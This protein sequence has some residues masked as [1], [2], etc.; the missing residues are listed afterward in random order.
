ML[1][2]AP[3]L[4][5]TACL[6]LAVIACTSPDPLPSPTTSPTSGLP[7]P[8]PQPTP[9][10]SPSTPAPTASPST[11][12]PTPSPTGLA[13]P[14]V[15]QRLPGVSIRDA[16][17]GRF[18]IPDCPPDRRPA[19]EPAAP[20]GPAVAGPV[21]MDL[22]GQIG[23]RP[24]ALVLE[25]RQLH[26]GVGARVVEFGL[27]PALHETSSSDL[28]PGIVEGLAADNDLLVAALGVDGLAVLER[29]GDG[30]RLSAVLEMPG[31]ALAATI[32]GQ[33]AFVA[34][35]TGGLRIV[36][37]ARPPD[38]RE[39]ASL[40]EHHH[41]RGVAV[42][43]GLAYVAAA[44]E[45]LVVVDVSDPGAPRE[46]GRRATG[47]F[48]FSVAVEDSTVYVAD[49]WG[50]LQVVDVADPAQPRLAGSL[51]T[52]G[53]AMDISLS[54]GVAYLAAGAQG[55]LAVD[56]TDAADLQVV[57]AIPLSLRHATGIAVAD[58]LAF[59]ADPFE[60]MHVVDVRS[61][62]APQAVAVWQPLLEGQHVAAA[63]GYAYVAGGRSGLVVVDASDPTRP[64][65]VDAQPT[66][67]AAASVVLA[68]DRV[69]FSTLND[70][71]LDVGFAL[72]WADTAGGRLSSAGGP[73]SMDHVV[74]AGT[75]LGPVVS[76]TDE[77]GL[78][79][80]DA[81]DS[82]PCR[83][84]FH[85]TNF[86]PDADVVA[87][88]RS[89][90][91]AGNTAYVT[92]DNEGIYVFDLADPQSPRLLSQ[93][94]AENGD[95]AVI[96]DWLYMV[97][98]DTLM[99]YEL[100]D[101]Q[102]PRLA[103]TTQLPAETLAT[104]PRRMAVAGGRL[105]IATGFGVLAID[106]SDPARP[107]VAGELAIPGGAMSVAG[108]EGN[109]YVGTEQ[110]GLVIVVLSDGTDGPT[111]PP[112]GPAVPSD[113]NGM[114][115]PVVSRAPDLPSLTE[116]VRSDVQTGC[117]VTSAEDAGPGS[118][119]DCLE[120]VRPGRAVVFDPA[121]FSP[122]RPITIRLGSA[123]PVPA[124]VVLDGGGGVVLDGGGEVE[125]GICPGPDG[126]AVTVRGM[127]LRGFAF[128][129]IGLESEGNVIEGNVIYGNGFV[130]VDLTGARGNRIV[131]NHISLDASGNWVGAP[132]DHV[133]T[134]LN[135][136][137]MNHIEGNAIGGRVFVDE[138]GSFN[139]AFLGNRVGVDADGRPLDC[140]CGSLGTRYYN[141]IGGS[142]PGEGNVIAPEI[143]IGTGEVVLGNV[144][145]GAGRAYPGASL[146]R[147]G[148]G[149]TVGGRSAGAGNELRGRWALEVARGASQGQIVGN[150]IAGG[151]DR[152]FGIRLR[153]TGAYVVA[154]ELSGAAEACIEIASGAASNWLLGNV[155]RDCREGVRIVDAGDNVLADNSFSGNRIDAT[156][157]GDNQWDLRGHG[158]YWADYAGHD[159]DG[160][161]IGDSPHAVPP[162]GQDRY[163]LI[164]PPIL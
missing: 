77:E 116:P 136:S 114:V 157:S 2:A 73:Y 106:V 3:R 119:R 36:N 64:R 29:G 55:L 143:H 134:L 108:D 131:N 132:A 141:R 109:L 43:G 158:N 68:G 145:G 24:Q 133:M 83:L 23:G 9:T 147:M 139:N 85:R 88:T 92:V 25:G 152:A 72:A 127:Q 129:G 111:P 135:G 164:E 65:Y 33:V 115:A 122:D 162:N 1:G 155:L 20:A 86:F 113:W 128:A 74:M 153:G 44:D 59:V 149:A 87:Y 63:D 71:S 46:L 110:A 75:A 102:R 144:I 105:V 126:R 37:L 82:S 27:D 14:E 79:Q 120:R 154:N 56:V 146:A 39:L 61:P 57:G 42:D 40:L 45:G 142:L 50:G 17:S 91:V 32:V 7:S 41:V 84:S 12:A 99:A 66:R 4:A 22:V 117:T 161:G 60:G 159:A 58:A 5:R 11:P 123:L 90:A 104:W 35:G 96:G 53:W 16:D 69:L 125:C 118:L 156:D 13:L 163:P 94:A 100:S 49:G 81:G 34:A 19:L 95:L 124:R 89:I 112:A 51:P 47:G 78:L 62:A 6:L 130:D 54:D 28:L 97:A 18:A 52:H 138:Q 38:A 150:T 137:A 151:R 48:A 98:H 8:S 148:R 93:T 160:D 31:P 101:P 103:S 26:V 140:A 76:Y 80:I 67:A 30:Q 21:E 10:A 70:A 15:H 121:V 107:R